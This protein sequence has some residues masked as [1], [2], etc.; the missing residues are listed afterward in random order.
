ML[1]ICMSGS[2]G[3][4]DETNH[5]SLP[6]SSCRRYRASATV[7]YRRFVN[8]WA[9]ALRS[10]QFDSECA[11]MARNV[12]ARFSEMSKLQT[13][14]GAVG[15]A[16]SSGLSRRVSA[17]A[18]PGRGY[19]RDHKHHHQG[20]FNGLF[21]I[22]IAAGVDAGR[23]VFFLPSDVIANRFQVFPTKTECS[24]TLLPIQ[25]VASARLVISVVNG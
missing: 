17:P 6:L 14:G 8:C 12:T 13:H 19:G 2:E 11:K 1:E 16:A 9:C 24:A 10:V 20:R 23:L 3:G 22:A 7:T 5:L 4:G 15:E 25:P 18:F 21:L